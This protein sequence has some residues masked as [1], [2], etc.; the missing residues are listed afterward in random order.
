MYFLTG[1]MMQGCPDEPIMWNSRIMFLL[2][3][4]S[5]WMIWSSYSAT[6]TSFLSVKIEEPP[7][8]D[9]ETMLYQ[10]NYKIVTLEGFFGLDK[11]RVHIIEKNLSY[12]VCLFG[13][14]ISVWK[15]SGERNIPV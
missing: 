3:Y 14:M 6:L 8:L 9:L 12:C 2:V 13:S 1:F 15:P 10:T 5:C 11:F 7:F 4:F